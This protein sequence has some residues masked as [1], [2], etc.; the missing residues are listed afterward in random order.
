MTNKRKK[1]GCL[2]C[3]SRKKK[4]DENR[5]DCHFC[6]AKQV[7]C[8][9]PDN[10]QE[11]KTAPAH[12]A[13]A[14]NTSRRRHKIQHRDLS[15]ADS[16]IIY[17]RVAHGP[18]RV[19]DEV[20]SESVN[21]HISSVT[22]ADD[23]SSFDVPLVSGPSSLE[24]RLHPTSSGI[25]SKSMPDSATLAALINVSPTIQHIPFILNSTLKSDTDD[26]QLLFQHFVLQSMP[27]IAPDDVDLD[28]F[29]KYTMPL[30]LAD[31]LVMRAALALSSAKYMMRDPTNKALHLSGLCH[32]R[33]MEAIRTRITTCKAGLDDRPVFLCAATILMAVLELTHGSTR[34]HHIDFATHLILNVLPSSVSQI[35]R[36]LY[37]FLLRTC[38]YLRAETWGCEGPTGLPAD[39]EKQMANM[40]QLA[41]KLESLDNEGGIAS[42]IGLLQTAFVTG[43]V[44]LEFDFNTLYKLFLPC[45][46]RPQGFMVQSTVERLP[47]TPEFHVDHD[48]RTVHLHDFVIKDDEDPGKACT[49]AFQRVVDAAITSDSFPSLNK[50]HSEHFRIIGAN[51]FVSIERFPAPLFGISSRG[52]HMTAYI[53][54]SEGMKIWVPRRSAHL[55]TFPNLLDTTVAGGVKAEDSPFDCI[56]A[57]ATE[58]ASLPADFVKENARAVGAV[59]YCS[60]NKQRGTFFPTVLY[61]YDLELP[62]SIEPQ[63][64]DDEVSGFELMTIDQVKDAMLGEQF[65]PNCVLVM[66][67]FFIRHNIITSENND[68]YLEIVTRMRRHLPVP[69]SPERRR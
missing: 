9:W 38:I 54:T 64:G 62:E 49:S 57:E 24:R 3:R 1:T 15:T 27:S 28:L 2:G 61:V 23:H 66:L 10:W 35:D 41:A 4:C 11:V 58:E 59:T 68:E 43:L 6:V 51:H 52:A 67:D 25:A 22:A 36:T 37:R 53:K 12:N 69:T 20:V 46:P 13:T 60:L 56:I 33:V 45:D 44:P 65:K 29:L 55:F 42:Q 5:P 8:I 17:E 21:Q 7:E 30:V 48:K 26:F 32:S 47:W 40:F 18:T 14:P 16:G 34:S 50:L 39:V 19:V 63:P 31:D